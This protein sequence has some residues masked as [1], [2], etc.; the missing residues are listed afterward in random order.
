M[1]LT[2][3][4]RSSL[5]EGGNPSPS[6]P[7]SPTPPRAFDFLFTRFPGFRGRVTTA[8]TWH[9]PAAHV[10]RFYLSNITI[11]ACRAKDSMVTWPWESRKLY[12]ARTQTE[13]C[14]VGYREPFAILPAVALR[15]KAHFDEQ[16]ATWKYSDGELVLQALDTFHN[17]L[18]R[19]PIVG[20]ESV[21]WRKL[22]DWLPGRN[23]CSKASI[24]PEV[25]EGLLPKWLLYGSPND[26]WFYCLA[27]PERFAVRE[28]TLHWWDWPACP[29]YQREGAGRPGRMR[30]AA[31]NDERKPTNPEP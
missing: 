25:E 18:F 6:K 24:E 13:W 9:G 7:M 17:W 20:P 28:A 30:Q 4:A 15:L 31:R 5:G 26:L 19:R 2:L 16:L 14:I 21:H 27:H 12:F 23:I 8:L 22:G 11:E 29:P 1:N 10:G 3:L